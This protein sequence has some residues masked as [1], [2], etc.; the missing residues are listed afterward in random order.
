MHT[1]GESLGAS[2]GIL[3][4]GDTSN[5]CQYIPLEENHATPVLHDSILW[6]FFFNP[7]GSINSGVSDHECRNRLPKRTSPLIFRPNE[8]YP[9]GHGIEFVEGFNW[10]FLLYCE[11][12]IGLLAVLFP[13][14][15]M[16]FSG[17]PDKV[18]TALAAGQWIFGAGQVFYV[19]ILA[20][21]ESLLLLR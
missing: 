16:L 10:R 6:D 20:L 19:V 4:L 5:T 11:S 3:P 1:L 12:S 15:W 17:K 14:L 7:E 2:S 18:A 8:G 13:F 9:I 21:S